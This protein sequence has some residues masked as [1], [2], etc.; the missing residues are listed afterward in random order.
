MHNNTIIILYYLRLHSAL[1]ASYLLSAGHNE[2]NGAVHDA[3][4]CMGSFFFLA[5][6]YTWKRCI[7][8]AAQCAVHC[9]AWSHLSFLC[10]RVRLSD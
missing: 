8:N 6:S 5:I 9:A 4:R 2:G 7:M 3:M 10:F 1:K